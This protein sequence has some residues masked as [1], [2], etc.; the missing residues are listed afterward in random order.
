MEGPLASHSFG[1]ISTAPSQ[2]SFVATGN[3]ASLQ[4]QVERITQEGQFLGVQAADMQQL[5]VLE[6]Q[7]LLVYRHP[8]FPL[9]TKI[10]E[11]CE[12]AT[13]SLDAVNSQAFDQ[14]I[15][16]FITQEAKEGKPFFTDDADADQLVCLLFCQP[17]CF[18]PIKNI[19]LLPTLEYQIMVL[20]NC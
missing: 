13:N 16:A 5:G 7:K 10:F 6:N 4:R 11:K 3:V 12:F 2:Q 1:Q 8:L 17:F 18:F 9:L 19:F 15:K 20:P 14:E